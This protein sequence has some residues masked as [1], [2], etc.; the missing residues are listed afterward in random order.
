MMGRPSLLV[1]ASTLV[2]VL[3]LPPPQARQALALPS[4]L[5]GPTADLLPVAITAASATFLAQLVGPLLRLLL[6]PSNPALALVNL[7]LAPANLALAD[8]TTS[9]LTLASGR[10]H[11]S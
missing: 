10:A 4:I 7:A 11:G 5:P 2:L 3:A 8:L 1:L 9:P 6:S